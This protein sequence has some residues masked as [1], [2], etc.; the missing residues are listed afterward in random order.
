MA[1]RKSPALWISAVV[2]TSVAAAGYEFYKYLTKDDSES[3]ISATKFT[4]KSIALTLL[5]SVL[6]SDLPLEEI[7]LNSQNV[8][9]ILP[10]HL[11][12]DDLADNIDTSQNGLSQTLLNNYKLLRCLNIDGYFHMLKNLK[13]DTLIVCADD[14]GILDK[15]PKD[16]PRFVNE[17]VTLEQNKERVSSILTKVFLR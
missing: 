7:I 1:R 2:A 4:N 8:T 13:P 9:F 16:L 11:L 3:G 6:S 12:V 15:M 17:V 5:H 10:P 14:L